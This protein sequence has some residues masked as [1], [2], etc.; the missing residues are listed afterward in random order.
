MRQGTFDVGTIVT[1]KTKVD[2]LGNKPGTLGLCYA[3]YGT[4]SSFI[5]ENGNYDG[6]SIEEQDMMLDYVGEDDEIARYE[7]QNVMKVSADFS[8]GVFDFERI[9]KNL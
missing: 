1:I 8:K 4:G 2:L 6:F 3:A 5:F 9:K 7:F